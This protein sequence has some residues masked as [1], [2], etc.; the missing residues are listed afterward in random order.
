[1]DRDELL[2][3]VRELATEI[4]SRPDVQAQANE[5]LATQ[6]TKTNASGAT[7]QT[8]T[9]PLGTSIPARVAAG[10]RLPELNKGQHREVT[11]AGTDTSVRQVQSPYREGRQ[12]QLVKEVTNDGLDA[13]KYVDLAK[14]FG[15]NGPGLAQALISF[16]KTGKVP[17]GFDSKQIAALQELMFSQE[18]I[19]SPAALV[20]AQMSLDL[21]AKNKATPQEIF[22]TDPK[23]GGLFPMSAKGAQGRSAQVDKALADPSSAGRKGHAARDV[24]MQREVA[25]IRTWLN[26]LDLKFAQEASQEQKIVEIKTQIRH[27]MLRAF[28]L[29]D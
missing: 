9:V 24:Q 4:L 14:E 2:K 12:H 21:M 10:Q 11:Y 15:S 23:Q 19:R 5:I 22:G 25:L 29:R 7:I 27:R 17:E 6:G 16:R 18:T 20:Q 8:V 28:G 26:A 1:M 3:Y 13:K